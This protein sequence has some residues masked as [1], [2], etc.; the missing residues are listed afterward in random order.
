MCDQG[1]RGEACDV[2]YA[3]AAPSFP[4]CPM[5]CELS[6]IIQKREL[7]CTVAT[8]LPNH[9]APIVNAT[10]M[11]KCVDFAA[12]AVDTPL[13]RTCTATGPCPS[14]DLTAVRATLVLEGDISQLAPGSVERSNFV[15]QFKA[16]IVR[17]AGLPTSDVERITIVSITAASI[18]VMFD[19]AAGGPESV[20]PS[21]FLSL[22][23][24]NT[25]NSF[26]SSGAAPTIG[27]IPAAV[28]ESGV[29]LGVIGEVGAVAID[30][31]F[32]WGDWGS[33]GCPGP[34]Q[35][36]SV[37]VTTEGADGGAACP[38]IETK[39][40]S[41]GSGD[42][43]TATVPPSQPSDEDSSTWLIILVVLLGLVCVAGIAAAGVLFFT[44]N[45][46]RNEDDK[47]ADLEFDDSAMEF[48]NPVEGAFETE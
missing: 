29:V 47:R 41:L 30:C 13:Q 24:T 18:L 31:V 27:G 15:T 16:D 46:T 48:N 5:G 33:C 25:E 11:E 14:K 35:T 19:I 39:S 21:S 6:Q 23:E 8:R 38:T 12:P 3:Y 20:D 22:L 7:Y 17:L 43:V 32:E 10:S 4:D 28:G 42:C 34:S 37:V 9:A 44:Q 1:Y 36:R 2:G 26:M 45:K 40:C